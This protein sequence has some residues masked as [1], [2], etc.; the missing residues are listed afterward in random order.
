MIAI[1][2][3]EF[4]GV[5]TLFVF[6]PIQMFDHCLAKLCSWQGDRCLGYGLGNSLLAL[7]ALVLSRIP[8]FLVGYGERI[9][10]NPRF[11]P[12]V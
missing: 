8:V 3:P 1:V 9:R 2:G 10:T 11:Q 5:S 12:H 7:I 6:L 4:I